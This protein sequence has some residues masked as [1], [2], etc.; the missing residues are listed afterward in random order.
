MILE[1][2][3]RFKLLFGRASGY[4]GILN[5]L[6]ILANLKLSYGIKLSAFIIVPIGFVGILVIGSL[7]YFLI[8]RREMKMCNTQNDLKHQLNRIEAILEN[9]SSGGEKKQ[10]DQR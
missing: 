9:M 1:N 4:M 7:D 3:A 10:N 6:M 8:M 5:F 2:I